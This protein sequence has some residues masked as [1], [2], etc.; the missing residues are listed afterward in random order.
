MMSYRVQAAR[1]P[2]RRRAVLAG[3]QC[4]SVALRGADTRVCSV[5]THRDAGRDESR[6]LQAEACATTQVS[7]YCQ[8]ILASSPLF[9]ARCYLFF[10]EFLTASQ[11]A[12]AAHE[13]G[14]AAGVRL[15]LDQAFAGYEDG[16]G[17][18][19]CEKPEQSDQRQLARRGRERR[20]RVHSDFVLGWR[21][22]L[23]PARVLLP[24]RKAG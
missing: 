4:K 21:R 3:T 16:Q 12:R 22:Q 7:W 15:S 6:G 20:R 2:R 24:V 19:Q 13:G 10:I 14:Y 8:F 11:A 17:A 1:P 23:P 18:A 5:P 9:V